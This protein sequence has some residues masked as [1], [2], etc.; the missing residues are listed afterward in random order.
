ML[1]LAVGRLEERKGTDILLHAAAQ[2]RR[3]GHTFRV[4]FVG[5]GQCDA[6]VRLAQGL[7]IAPYIRFLGWV[8]DDEMELI[9]MAADIFAF[10]SRHEGFG[11]VSFEAMAHGLPVVVTR[12]GAAVDGLIDDRNGAV[13]TAGRPADLADALATLIADGDRRAAIGQ[14][15]RRMIVQHLGWRRVA[16]ETVRAYTEAIQQRRW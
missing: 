11:M 15:N 9:Y 10:P 12:T 2:L 3:S 4:V 6:Y 1:I 16:S 5:G 8:P 7:G 14:H 13:V